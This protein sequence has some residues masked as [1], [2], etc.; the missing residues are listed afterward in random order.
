VIAQA[1]ALMDGVCD[2]V[3]ELYALECSWLD[4]LNGRFQKGR[5]PV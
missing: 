4:L 3:R 1:A 2:L 5:V